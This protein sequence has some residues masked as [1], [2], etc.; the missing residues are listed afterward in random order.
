M[1]RHHYIKKE[2]QKG[3]AHTHPTALL[4]GLHLGGQRGVKP[5]KCKEVLCKIHHKV[6]KNKPQV[7]SI[8]IKK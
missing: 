4:L 8:L 3:D 1:I 6:L 2:H 7:I 5:Q